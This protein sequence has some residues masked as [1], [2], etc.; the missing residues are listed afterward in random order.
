MDG[1]LSDN[2]R[3]LSGVSYSKIYKGNSGSDCR[4]FK[5]AHKEQKQANMCLVVILLT[6]RW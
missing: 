2:I 1:H 4:R 6:D 5:Y 3:V